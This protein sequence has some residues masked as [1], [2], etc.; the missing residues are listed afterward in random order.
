MGSCLVAW[1]VACLVGAALRLAPQDFKPHNILLASPLRPGQPDVVKLVDFGL[2]KDSAHICCAG[3]ALEQVNTFIERTSAD[4]HLG[5][6]HHFS[7]QNTTGHLFAAF[8][9]VFAAASALFVFVAF[10][11]FAAAAA[12]TAAAPVLALWPQWAITTCCG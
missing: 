4:A 11:A 8:A 6:Q 2:S 9:S 7:E 12:A 5:L 10:A 1:L 3:P